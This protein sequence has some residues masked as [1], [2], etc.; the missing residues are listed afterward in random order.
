MESALWELA[1]EGAP[2]DVVSV[3]ARL[4]EDSPPP[5]GLTIVAR[6]GLIVTARIRRA[7]LPRVRELVASMKRPQDYAPAP[8]DEGED[9]ADDDVQPRP[10][11]IRRG[12]GPPTGRG[13]V[14]AHLDWGFDFAHPAFRT[15]DGRTRLLALWDQGG[16]YDP[17]RPN[18]YGFGRIYLRD[19]IDRALATPNPYRALGYRWYTSDRGS[20]SHGTHTFG[21]SAGGG[22]DGLPPGLAPDADLVFVDLTTRTR[23][24]PQ[25][26]GSSTDLLEGCAF[27]DEIAGERPLVINTSLGRQ[28]G[29]HDGLTLTET[30]LDHFVSCRAGRAIA[31]S[32]GNYYAKS[33]HAQLTI[34][35]GETRRL[36]LRLAPGSRKAELDLWYPR[37]DRLVFRLEGPE[38]LSVG[39][40]GPNERG[41]LA[42]GGRPAARLYHRSD[43]P[44]NGDNQVSLYV[45]AAAPPGAWRLSIEGQSVGDGRIH[46][47]VERD[48]AGASRLAFADP[49]VDPS[50]TVGTICNGFSTIAVAALRPPFGRTRAGP[51]LQLRSDARRALQPA[52]PGRPRLQ[53]PERAVAPAR[54]DRR[55]GRQPDVR[56]QHGRAACRRGHCPDV[57]GRPPAALD[58][59]G[60]GAAR[61]HRRAGAGGQPAQAWSRL[62]RQRSRGRRRSRRVAD[63]AFGEA[64]GRG[65]GPSSAAAA[66]FR[67][68][69]RNVRV[70]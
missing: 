8:A 51:L 10:S 40:V 31:M 67:A 30:A 57:R 70:R 27:A 14:V 11:D 2:D 43:D 59:R 9:E 53:D 54:R 19:E 65:A 41:D 52:D 36:G 13:V 63:T 6:F 45:Y 33:A 62:S 68:G 16:A 48:P 4:H 20:G 58:R 61:R 64:A 47:W 26:L 56:H 17:A 39:P 25:P 28:A 3:I 42:H 46:A 21:I 37:V 32:C 24:G 66:S 55:A 5:P 49:D 18:R 15:A 12:S 38:G 22:C 60:T 69:E 50:A 7:D 34:L 44:N 35:P 29:Q 23:Q 1:G